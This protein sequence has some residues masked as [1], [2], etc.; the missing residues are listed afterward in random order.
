MVAKAAIGVEVRHA[1]MADLVDIDIYAAQIRLLISRTSS[2]PSPQV[3]HGRCRDDV[4][5]GNATLPRQ[6]TATKGA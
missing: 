5:N 3:R 2:R 6:R 1:R 4:F